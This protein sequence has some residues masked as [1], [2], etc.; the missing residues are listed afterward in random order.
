MPLVDDVIARIAR[1]G[2]M[3][4]ADYMG[5]CLTHPSQ[6]YYMSGDPLASPEATAA[7]SS[8]PRRSARCSGS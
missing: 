4:L 7:T 3:S 5:L 2:P 1:Q 8:P 6:G